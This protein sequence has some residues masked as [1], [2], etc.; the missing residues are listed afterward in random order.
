MPFWL[1]QLRE[2]AQNKARFELRSFA[3]WLAFQLLAQQAV[4]RYIPP[5]RLLAG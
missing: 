2:D 1:R 5:L 4:G 3:A